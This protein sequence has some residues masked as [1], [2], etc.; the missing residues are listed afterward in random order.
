MAEDKTLLFL[1][2]ASGD[3]LRAAKR[4]GLRVAMLTDLELT[5]Q[6][7]YIDDV[8]PISP[9][10]RHQTLEAAAEYDR[11]HTLNAIM[12]FD[13]RC[14]PITALVANHLH[15]PGN[16]YEAAYAARNKFVMRN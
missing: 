6:R 5:W 16:A 12:T 8:I 3:G 1:S 7:E 2:M 11:D 14:V 9:F 15:L 13:E 4:L 10:N